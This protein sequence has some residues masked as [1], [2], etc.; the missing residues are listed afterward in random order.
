MNGIQKS[1][2]AGPIGPWYSG[3]V[4]WVKAHLQ[5][6]L[7]LPKETEIVT[8]D[9]ARDGVAQLGINSDLKAGFA[10]QIFAVAGNALASKTTSGQFFPPVV[11][12]DDVGL[13]HASSNSGIVRPDGTVDRDRLDVLKSFAKGKDYLTESDLRDFLWSRFFEL[14]EGTVPL[15]ERMRRVLGNLVLS[16][17]EFG[18]LFTVASIENPKK[19]G[20][21]ILKLSSIDEFYANNLFGRIRAEREAA[22][23]VSGVPVHDGPKGVAGALAAFARSQG[24]Q[25]T[26][27]AADLAAYATE[28]LQGRTQNDIA[29]LRDGVGLGAVAGPAI[30]TLAPNG[31][32]LALALCPAFRGSMPNPA[33]AGKA[34]RTGGL[35]EDQMRLNKIFD[36]APRALDP[37]AD[38]ALIDE[39]REARATGDFKQLF[40]DGGVG[41]R[42]FYKEVAGGFVTWP[43]LWETD[44]PPYTLRTAA[45]S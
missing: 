11:I 14:Q 18:P 36:D 8:Y 33:P 7:G 45:P 22:M 28:L 19:K 27:N 34:L 17:G 3:R 5:S 15:R 40:H 10:A 16:R 41:F 31:K 12:L 30:G 4:D 24:R 39:M 37:T 13:N 42:C 9:L 20:E 35:P 43:P 23:I 38:A 2:G 29:R 21:R 26:G 6:V 1:S 25:L 32:A 44:V